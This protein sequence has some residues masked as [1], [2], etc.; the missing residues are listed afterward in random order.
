MMKKLS[1]FVFFAVSSIAFAQ[2]K[3]TIAQAEASTDPK[4]LANF[5]K[6]NPDHP[7]TPALKQKL[8]AVIMDG[9]PKAAKPTVT[10]LSTAKLKIEVKKDIAKGKNDAHTQKTVDLLNHLFSNDPNRREAYVA[11]ENK[12]KCNMIVKISGKKFYNLDVKAKDQNFILVDKGTYTM[13]TTICDAKYSSV[14]TINKD[15]IVSLNS[16]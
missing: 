12:S 6:F 7:K 2:S 4:V 8:Y 5:I 13:T 15:I 1:I 14:K 16:K 10:P 11:I 9:N 3:Y